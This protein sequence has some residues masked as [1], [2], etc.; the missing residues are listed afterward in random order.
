MAAGKESSKQNSSRTRGISTIVKKKCINCKAFIITKK[1]EVL[2]RF[3]LLLFMLVER[4]KGS[5][6]DNV[7]SCEEGWN[8]ASIWFDVRGFSCHL[9]TYVSIVLRYD[10]HF[11]NKLNF[12]FSELCV[13][14]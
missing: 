14:Y 9:N 2:L 1:N 10:M 4:W 5:C 8:G 13:F 12:K 11:D 3:F 6:N 7:C